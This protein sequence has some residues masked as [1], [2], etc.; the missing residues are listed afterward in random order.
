MR[1]GT[2]VSAPTPR[3]CAALT[4]EAGTWDAGGAPAGTA[5]SDRVTDNGCGFWAI[6]AATASDSPQLGQRTLQPRYSS[7]T[8]HIL[9]QSEFGHWM[10]TGIGCARPDGDG[11][12]V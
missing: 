1:L 7:A 3:R 5:A 2:A 11:R 12:G 10:V 6:G 4:S 9:P 8:A